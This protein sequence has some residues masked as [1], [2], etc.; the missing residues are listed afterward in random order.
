MPYGV[1]GAFGCA[2]MGRHCLRDEMRPVRVCGAGIDV[3]GKWAPA[4]GGFAVCQ[5][6]FWGRVAQKKTAHVAGGLFQS[7]VS[8]GGSA[9][10]RT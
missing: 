1:S 4:L 2:G 9:P 6:R 5:S 10:S 8:H 3:F 7:S